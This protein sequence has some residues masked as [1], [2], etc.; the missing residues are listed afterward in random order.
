MDNRL[1]DIGASVLLQNLN[2]N[3]MYLDLSNNNIGKFGT[4]NL[5]KFL[6]DDNS[7]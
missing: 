7:L 2:K 3:I 6:I 5:Y 4:E 1:T